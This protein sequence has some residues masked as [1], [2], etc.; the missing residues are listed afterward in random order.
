MACHRRINV[1]RTLDNDG[2]E[3]IRTLTGLQRDAEAVLVT[4]GSSE[5]PLR[6]PAA[7]P[8]LPDFLK[9]GS[10]PSDISRPISEALVGAHLDSDLGVDEPTMGSSMFER[11]EFGSLEFHNSISATL[12]SLPSCRADDKEASII[13]QPETLARRQSMLP[14]E[15]IIDV[16][17][18]ENKEDGS[19]T[20]AI[21]VS[22]SAHK[23]AE[24]MDVFS[25]DEVGLD[26]LTH[27]G[28]EDL[29]IVGVD[30]GPRK[31][32]LRG[33]EQR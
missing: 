6:S 32:L 21:V 4:E 17:Y 14:W 2:K 33:V 1:V 20:P 16:C 9:D 11:P 13:A 7:R 28:E 23:L 30:L 8:S 18:D 15:D 19:G 22:L 25:G 26:A 24:Y 12:L 10:P 27:P 5:E 29:K 31:K 3:S